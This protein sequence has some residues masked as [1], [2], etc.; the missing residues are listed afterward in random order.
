M[1]PKQLFWLS[2]KPA[3]SELILKL[4]FS[5]LLSKCVLE[6]SQEITY[7]GFVINSAMMVFLSQQ[8]KKNLQYFSTQAVS[9]QIGK[10]ISS[11]LGVDLVR[12]HYR[13]L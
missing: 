3:V 8:K 1:E 10:I 6:P 5:I 7:L 12:L 11:L 4:D 2:T 9:E 13:V